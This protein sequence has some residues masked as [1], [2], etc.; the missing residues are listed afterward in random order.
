M[1]DRFENIEITEED[2]EAARYEIWIMNDGPA[3]A[4]TKHKA[5]AEQSIV[6]D[7]EA[8]GWDVLSKEIV[9][10]LLEDVSKYELVVRK[11][12]MVKILRWNTFNKGWMEKSESG[13]WLIFRPVPLPKPTGILADVNFD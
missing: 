3:K 4:T 2:R 9:K 1:S 6:E 12:D 13:G 8:N 10:P 11:K 7:L 5:L